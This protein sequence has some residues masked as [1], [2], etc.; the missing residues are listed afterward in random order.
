[1]T[2]GDQPSGTM[3]GANGT[4]SCYF[5]IES[6]TRPR[7]PYNTNAPN[8]RNGWRIFGPDAVGPNDSTA[9]LW[10]V[11][12]PNGEPVLCTMSG[13]KGGMGLPSFE[14]AYAGECTVSFLEP[15]PYFFPIL[16]I[17]E[18]FSELVAFV[19]DNTVAPGGEF[20]LCR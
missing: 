10:G 17:T 11:Y 1:M 16:I 14:T 12:D 20:L 4:E 8:D 9:S 19:I 6:Q 13:F 2:R 15:Y 18:I 7:C 5:N 3:C